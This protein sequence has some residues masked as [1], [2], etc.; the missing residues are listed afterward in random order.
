MLFTL[1]YGELI[2]IEFKRGEVVVIAV[3]IA[4]LASI[5]GCCF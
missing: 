4:S 5:Y 2:E 1:V 3:I